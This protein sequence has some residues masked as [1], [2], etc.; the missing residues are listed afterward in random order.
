MNKKKAHS[1]AAAGES[2]LEE[3]LRE[4]SVYPDYGGPPIP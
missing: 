2:T 4:R 1:I 3:N